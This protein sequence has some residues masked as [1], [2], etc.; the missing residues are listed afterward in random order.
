MI[1][2]RI[3][4]ET[5]AQTAYLVACER[6]RDAIIVDPERDIDRVLELVAREGLHLIAAVETHIHADFVS[7][8]PSLCQSHGIPAWVSG[9]CGAP[10]WA[11]TV[12]ANARAAM[13]LLHDGDTLSVGDLSLRVL[14]TPGHT[15]EAITLAVLDEQGVVRALLT[16]DFLFAGSVGRPDV[17]ARL[18][19]A[20]ADMASVARKL[21][22]ALQRLSN[23]GDNVLIYPGHSTG[24]ACGGSISALPVSRLDIERRIN[25]TLKESTGEEQAFSDK[26]MSKMPDPPS[27]F[28]RVKALNSEGACCRA[29]DV[30]PVIPT[31]DAS[32]FVEAASHPACV[33]IDCRA[34]ARFNDGFL[35]GSIS[36]PMDRLFAMG[37]G[38]YLESGD[39]VL[40][41]CTEPERSC[42]VRC[43][44]RL[45]VDRFAGWIPPSEYDRIPE[46]ALAGDEIEEIAAPRALQRWQA[47]EATFVDVRNCVEYEQG[48][49]PGAVFAPFSQLP[50]RAMEW[51]RAKPIICYCRSG[52]RSARACSYLRRRGFKV[53]NMRGGYWPWAGR[54]F[55]VERG[56]PDGLVS[57]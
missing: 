13:R 49:L 19:G 17:G 45:G 10:S 16:G 33:V 21:Q 22:R 52:N 57:C 34:W 51:D 6:T 32:T 3:H 55:E 29:G 11:A 46:A 4:D 27:Y 5:L 8:V 42:A 14:H 7:G 56:A 50:D 28:A 47:G 31:L 39:E 1:L 18:Q 38:S 37:A 23:L 41:V 54:G 26:V 40:L 35:P 9:V 15:P 24:S 25:T 30:P 12:D 2:R 20:K 44:W 53:S 43:L 36:A 48:H